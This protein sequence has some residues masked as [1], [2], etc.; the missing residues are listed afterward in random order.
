MG[1]GV[2]AKHTGWREAEW[3]GGR[4]GCASDA[5][6]ALVGGATL[7]ALSWIGGCC[8]GLSW[9]GGCW[10]LDGQQSESCSTMLFATDSWFQLNAR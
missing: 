1:V 9:T 8:C 7:A 6:A 3:S 5:G 10:R 4:W 2:R